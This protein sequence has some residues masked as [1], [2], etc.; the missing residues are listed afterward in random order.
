MQFSLV[1]SLSEVNEVNKFTGRQEE[2]AQMQ[3]ILTTSRDRTTVVVHGLGGMGKTQL[4]IEFT[5]QNHAAYSAVFWMNATDEA[6]LKQSFVK[7]AERIVCEHPS[8]AYLERAIA[9]GEISETVKAVKAWLNERNNNRWLIIYDNY[10]HP[11]LG[12]NTGMD[13]RIHKAENQSIG[14]RDSWQNDGT[15]LK[16]F[17]IRP[18]FPE[19]R[20][21]A[22]IVT[23]RSSTVKLGQTLRLSKLKKMEDSL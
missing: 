11:H 14:R 23:T 10:D 2:L 12:D 1:F 22:I 16:A 9:N 4:A 17:D 21:G 20:H 6:T 13:A 19:S 7:V 18:F 3:N 15:L 5:K 8:V